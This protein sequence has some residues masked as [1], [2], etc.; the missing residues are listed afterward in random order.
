MKGEDIS[1]TPSMDD[2]K[3]ELSHSFRKLNP[4]DVVKG[5]VIGVSDTE[6]TVD[7]GSYS[8]GIIKLEE[9]S[10]DP[11]FSIKADIKVGDVVSATMI[12]EDREGNILLSMKQ[13]DDL[14][15]WDELKIM[16]QERTISKI[17]VMTSV[18]A[19]V[20]TFIKGVRAFIPASQLDLQYVEDT[21]PYVGRTLDVIVI[22][23]DA[24]DKKVVLSA[25]EV[26]RDRAAADKSS[27]ISKLQIGLVTTGTVEK[28]TNFGAFVNI[29][30]GLSGL[31]HISQ[32]CGRRIKSPKE[33]ISEGDTVTVKIMDVKDGKISLSMKAANENEEVYEDAVEEA[34]E[35][36]S[37]GGETGTSLAGLLAKLKL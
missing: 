13:A 18:K 34:A 8:E 30:E 26:L 10:N 22:D 15:A 32:I 35:E 14:L 17:K 4:G 33:V 5:T 9:L 11:R 2:Y 16:K 3:E 24:E 21:E 6:V 7:L 31:V 29:G 25:K 20:T 28:I 12:R 1:K 27:R 23:V 37:D 19:G 36:Y